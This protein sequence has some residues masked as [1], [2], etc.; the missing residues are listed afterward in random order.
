MLSLKIDKKLV[1]NEVKDYVMI[2]LGIL[3][4]AFCFRGFIYPHNITTGGLAGIASVIGWA[5]NIDMSIPYNIINV[6]LLIIAIIILGWRF[7]IRTTFGVVIVGTLI[8]VVGKF[9]KE[10]LLPNDPALAVVIGAI[11]VGC[12]LGIVFSANGSTGGTDILAMIMNKYRPIPIGRALMLM[13]A[14]ILASSYF[15]FKDPDKLLYSILQVAVANMTVDFFLNGYRQS[16]QF[17]IISSKYDEIS[18][19]ILT[20]VNR[21][22]TLLNGEGAYSK[23]EVKIMMVI[24]RR[25]EANHIFRIVKDTDPSA[26]ITQSLVR[27]VYGQGFDVIK[28]NNKPK[29][30]FKSPD[31]VPPK[32]KA[33]VIDLP[34][35]IEDI[36]PDADTDIEDI[37]SGP[38]NE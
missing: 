34:K 37:I 5:L 26:F 14:V 9:F 10:P 13:D 23:K 11:G 20:E 15:L 29:L 36:L 28:V 4:Y 25:T 27:G 21:G 2:F 3:L 38:K 12:S 31:G 8:Q 18:D 35:H 19:R 1:R 17:F 7:T 6:S 22:C 33:P 24:A 32:E 30:K 16:M